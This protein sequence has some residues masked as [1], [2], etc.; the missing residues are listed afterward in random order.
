MGVAPVGRDVGPHL[1]QCGQGFA[2]CL[3]H[4]LCSFRRGADSPRRALAVVRR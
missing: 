2:L 4:A 3:I 1:G